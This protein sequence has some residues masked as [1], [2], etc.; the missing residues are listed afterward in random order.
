[1]N[2]KKIRR[3]VTGHDENGKSKF[4]MDG[5]AES[6]LVVEQMGGLT[7]TDLWESY[8][9]PADNTGEKDNADRPVHLEPSSTGSIFRVVEFPPD[10]TWNDIAD[11]GSAFDELQAGHAADQTS[12]DASVHK[13]DTVDYALVL[14]GEIWAVMDTEER[15]MEQGD[16][17]V[18]RGTNHGWANKSDK[19]C[20]VM[21]VLCGANAV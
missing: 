8:E 5:I 19:N 1:M 11:S 2:A 20:R 17:L 14:E 15:L 13:T 16:V 7:A 6:I 10:S 9:A 21:F 3:L 12:G 4:I 18:Q